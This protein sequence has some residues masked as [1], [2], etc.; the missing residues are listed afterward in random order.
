MSGGPEEQDGRCADH[1][2]DQYQYQD[3]RQQ[4]HHQRPARAR[5]VRLADPHGG[6]GVLVKREDPPDERQ[7]AQEARHRGVANDPE[8]RPE[9]G[10]PRSHHQDDQKVRHKRRE[11]HPHGSRYGGYHQTP[12]ELQEALVAPGAE[13]PRYAPG[14]VQEGEQPDQERGDLDADQG[15]HQWTQEASLPGKPREEGP[16]LED[17]SPHDVHETVDRI[18]EVVVPSR[19]APGG[20]GSHLYAP[21][22][23]M[24]WDAVPQLYPRVSAHATRVAPFRLYLSECVEGLFS[25]LRLNGVLRS[26]ALPWC[27]D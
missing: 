14:D 24:Y 17:H 21:S 3:G 27:P 22:L 23:P 20:P 18:G 13:K 16:R 9:P 15:E 12:Q 2:H 26:S 8:G 25:E 6:Q 11:E 10:V 1:H 7:P 5:R 19:G 4:H